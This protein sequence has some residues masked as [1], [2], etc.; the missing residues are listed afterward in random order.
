M[1]GAE[2]KVYQLKIAMI[3]AVA[4]MTTH[5]EKSAPRLNATPRL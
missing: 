2:E 5:G 3:R 4:V 1:D